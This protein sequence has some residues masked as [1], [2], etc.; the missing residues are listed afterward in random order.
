[1]RHKIEY[2]IDIE[3]FYLQ[4]LA[5]AGYRASLQLTAPRWCEN[6]LL[7]PC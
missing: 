5:H 1:M 6:E 2:P 4:F 3:P 7:V